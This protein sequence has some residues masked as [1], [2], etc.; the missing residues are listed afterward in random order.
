MRNTVTNTSPINFGKTPTLQSHLF[1]FLAIA[2]A[3]SGCA[4]GPDYYCPDV[5]LSDRYLVQSAA[6]SGSAAAQSEIV[7]WWNGFGDPQL[8]RYITLALERN[9]DLAQAAARVTQSRAALGAASAALVPVGAVSAQA[10]RAYQSVETPLGQVLNAQAGFGRFGNEYRRQPGCALGTRPFWRFAPRTR[11]GAR[12][13][14]GSRRGGGGDATGSCG[15][16][17][18]HLHQHSKCASPPRRGTQAGQNQQDLLDMLNLL[19]GKGLVAAMQVSQAEGALA[20]VSAMVPVLEAGLNASMNA[21][22]VM[23]GTAPVTYR[24]A[25]V[26]VRAIPARPQIVVTGT[27]YDLLRRRPDLTAAESRLA[28]SHARIGMAMAEYYPKF[29]LSAMIGS[30]TSLSAGN[31]F[32]SGAS[33]GAGILG[34]LWRLFDFDR[35]HAQIDLARGQEAEALAAY[36]LSVLRATENVENSLSN[37]IQR[38][39]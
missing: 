15:T 25:L 29:S 3:V 20:Q 6:G 8:S 37:L 33:Q 1:I 34:L 17:C 5:Q 22:D 39:G 27:P 19:R 35:I 30:A 18:R 23:L 28:A 31:M 12:G 36:R 26:E 11:S 16:N 24:N 2:G 14:S 21:L 38:Q 4:V 10:A 32:A 7:A 13:I 9:L